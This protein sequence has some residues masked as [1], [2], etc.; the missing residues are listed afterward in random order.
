[1]CFV[2]LRF[3]IL[4]NYVYNRCNHLKQHRQSLRDATKNLPQPVRLLAL[5]WSLDQPWAT[6]HRICG[7]R[8]QQRGD[9]HQTLRADSLSKSHEEVIWMFI[10]G[11]E[12][13]T[14]QEVDNVIEMELEESLEDSVKRAVEGC[15]AVIG[16]EMPSDEK[17]QEG[18]DIVG[19]YAPKLRRPIDPKD[20]KKLDV[21]YYGLLAEV[22]LEELLDRA[23]ANENQSN[24][25]FWTQ[26]K[27]DNR[28]IKRPHVTIVHKNSITT[29]G[30][31]WNRCTALHEMSTTTPPLFKGTLR[32]LLWDGRVMA[33][34]LEDFDVV[35]AAEGSSSGSNNDEHGRGLVSNLPD[36]VRSRL[37]ITV[38]TKRKSIMPVEAKTMVEQWR[39]GEKPDEIKSIE[40]VDQVVYGRI[41]G[42]Q[43]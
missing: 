31:V 42:L 32:N 27:K 26:L 6:V 39:R 8:V 16:L 33:I 18:L 30:D 7:D 2:F 24:K 37:H 21:R 29:L 36:N 41:K 12:E 28:V 17:I 22:D 23:L 5:N 3:R 9:N 35:E 14:P 34:T 38:G 1:M 11:T 15:V 25:D 4:L 19:G 43:F 20:M 40:L 13:L 10:N